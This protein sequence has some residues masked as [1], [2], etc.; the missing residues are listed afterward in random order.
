VGTKLGFNAKTVIA[1]PVTIRQVLVLT[2]K[3]TI[4]GAAT[5]FSTLTAN[6]GTWD[7]GV[8]LTYQWSGS[9]G[10]TG[11]VIYG[12]NSASYTPSSVS[13]GSYFVVCVTGKKTPLANVTVCS[14]R[15]G[16]MQP[17]VFPTQP[18]PR[19]VGTPVS[20]ATLSVDVSGWIPGSAFRYRWLMNG[21]QFRYNGYSTTDSTF[22]L[23][24]DLLLKAKSMGF[25][26]LQVEITASK[27]G[28]ADA[29]VLSDS[30][31]F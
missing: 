21:S 19:I 11:W 10:G 31:D 12:A 8:S 26:K 25:N 3:P 15:F 9:Y 27:S 2:P 7:S 24:S 23:R 28:Y 18:K 17:A 4:S 30:V 13:D 20:E 22:Y 5:Y 16:P 14:D 29:I 6:P 1:S